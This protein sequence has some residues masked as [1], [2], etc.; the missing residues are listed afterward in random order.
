MPPNSQAGSVSAGQQAASP[1]AR[2]RFSG[3]DLDI[4]KPILPALALIGVVLAFAN[5]LMASAGKSPQF[6][7]ALSSC[8]VLFLATRPGGW[9]LTT[10]LALGIGLWVAYTAAYGIDPYFGW[11]PISSAGFL[12][13]ASLLMLGYMA[14]HRRKP[15]ELIVAAFFPGVSIM[16]GFVLPMTNRWSQLA[17]DAHLL[18]AD[19]VIGCQPSFILGRLLTNRPLLWNATATWYY[20]LPLAVGLLCAAHL[21]THRG[22]VRR[23]LWM[24]T[25][26]SLVGFFLYAVCPATGPAYAFHGRFPDSVPNLTGPAL[27]GLPVPGAPRNAMPSLHFSTALLVFWNTRVFRLARR[28]PAALFLAG[29]AFAILALGEHY[30]SDIV[31]AMPFSLFFQAA[32]WRGNAGDGMWKQLG[33]SCG[34]GLCAAWLLILRLSVQS[35]IARP[36]A[37][38]LAFAATVG[39]SIWIATKLEMCSPEVHDSE[40]VAD[41]CATDSR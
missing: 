13:I 19:G 12:G 31:V 4:L 15:W 16:V 41:R 3:E 11:V 34:A 24:F 22:E 6:S 28:L 29:T 1:L 10:V 14:V 2:P 37:T 18:A 36:V 25:S 30:L 35:L 38:S 32:F 26:M 20:A 40:A 7:F 33:M 8:F 9:Q 39:V 27:A 21:R 17:F 5:G 23:L